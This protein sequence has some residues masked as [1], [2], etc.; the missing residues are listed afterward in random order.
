MEATMAR[1]LWPAIRLLNS[2]RYPE[3]FLLVG[4]LIAIPLI[5]TINLLLSETQP[6]IVSTSN[7]LAGSHYIRSLGEVV[8][9]VHQSHDYVHVSDLAASQRQQEA[10]VARLT[11][12][13][14]DAT[15]QTRYAT[16]QPIQQL[17]ELQQAIERSFTSQDEEL[18]DLAHLALIAGLVEEMFRISNTSELILDPEIVTYYLMNIAVIQA[19]E[20]YILL[21]EV[22]HLAHEYETNPNEETRAELIALAGQLEATAEE[23]G[24][25]AEIAALNDPALETE[26]TAQLAEALAS[27]STL[28]NALRAS[29]ATNQL[30]SGESAQLSNQAFTT[31]RKLSETTL[32]LLDTHLQQRIN[33]LAGKN[34]LAMGITG[35]F[36]AV[37][38]YLLASLY[39]TLMYAIGLL[40]KA[41]QQLRDGNTAHPVTLKTRD[42]LGQIVT[43][44]NRVVGI[45][46]EESAKRQEAVE[47]QQAMQHSII[48]SQ[49]AN[50]HALEVPIIP[51]T[52]QIALL[53]LIGTINTQRAELILNTLLQGISQLRLRAVIIDLSGVRIVDSH[54]AQLLMHAATGGRLLGADIA[55]CGLTAE[56]AQTV[57]SLGISFDDLSVY[58]SL[59]EALDAKMTS[60]LVLPNRN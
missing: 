1:L 47:Q 14:N 30:T 17:L 36:I 16:E 27:F 55:L 54:V 42:E 35:A 60:R 8:D 43:S 57:V 45:L 10:I 19:P 11:A 23:T 51:L 9:I 25:A 49:E 29:D 38:I 40:D 39:N 53:P 21:S 7:E 32:D 2:L 6:R 34:Q 59:Q 18:I 20:Q 46:A 26:L 22:Y 4:L 12:L 31:S 48:Q 44:F 3:K 15:L 24:Y 5:L 41:S 58:A 37:M 56:L 52:N 13:K 33:Q 28:A 50:L